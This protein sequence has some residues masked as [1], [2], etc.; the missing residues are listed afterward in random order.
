[1]DTLPLDYLEAV[2]ERLSALH[3]RLAPGLT[4]HEFNDLEQRFGLRFPPDLRS[5]L[6]YMLPAH[7]DF[8]NWR[9]GA[10][11]ELQRDEDYLLSDIWGDIDG[12]EYFAPDGTG[13][14][15]LV[16]W[17]SKWWPPFWP[18]APRDPDAAYAI[19]AEQFANAPRLLRLYGHR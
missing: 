2:R 8:P 12:H 1:M 15:V 16:P 3:V 9:D 18:P 7:S 5:F 6:A 13:D 19:L 4:E 14:W 11:G 10:A 17:Q